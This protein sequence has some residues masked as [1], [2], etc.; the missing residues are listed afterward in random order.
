MEELAFFSYVFGCVLIPM[1]L[2]YG[3][4]RAAGNKRGIAETRG[5]FLKLL[6]FAVYIAGVFY[7]TGAGT[8]K[9]IRQYGT[10]P[11]I[12]RFSI[13]PFSASSFDV[14]AYLLNVVLL[15]PLG[16]LLP[17][18]WP[19]YNRFLRVVAYGAAVSL[20]IELSQLLNIRSTDVDDLLLNTFGAAAGFLLFRLFARA[21]KR[22]TA[23]K[24][25]CGYEAVLYLAAMYA[26][27][28]FLFNEIGFATWMYGF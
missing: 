1:L 9:N 24:N 4:Q 17:L 13:V 26:G 15:L 6:V 5:R 8:L 7:F 20:L 11:E 18:I 28:F 3:I 12:T 25:A 10:G 27:Y 2:V 22:K 14:T 16:F 23:A 19:E 21:S